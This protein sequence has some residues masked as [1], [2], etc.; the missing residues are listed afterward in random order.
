MVRLLVPKVVQIS[1][2]RFSCILSNARGISKLLDWYRDCDTGFRVAVSLSNTIACW[3]AYE[4][5]YGG[6]DQI[7]PKS[8]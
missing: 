5:I 2:G 3:T 4:T 1:I 8:G 7:P 6:K